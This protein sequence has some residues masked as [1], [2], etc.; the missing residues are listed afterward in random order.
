MEQDLPGDLT[1]EPGLEEP[2]LE[3]HLG[4][5]RNVEVRGCNPGC[6]LVLSPVTCLAMGSSQATH[7]ATCHPVCF[8]LGEPAGRSIKIPIFQ[9]QMLMPLF[10]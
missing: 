7:S 2:G 3:E 1:E 9:T 6:K 5:G 10:V 4:P 8:L